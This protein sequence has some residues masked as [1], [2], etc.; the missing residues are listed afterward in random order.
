M[1]AEAAHVGN[2]AVTPSEQGSGLGSR[3]L[4]LAEQRAIEDGFDRVH[5]EKRL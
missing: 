3:L 4:A 1:P 5:F 2:V